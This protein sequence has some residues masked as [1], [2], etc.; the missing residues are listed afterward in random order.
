MK[1]APRPLLA[2]ASRGTATQ[3]LVA[4]GPDDEQELDRLATRSPKVPT[5]SAR[6]S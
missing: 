4:S 2:R 6:A 1:T 5:G 3:L